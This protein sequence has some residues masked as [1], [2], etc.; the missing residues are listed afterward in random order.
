MKK[1][2]TLRMEQEAIERAKAYAEAR[3]TS[4]SKLVEHFFGALSADGGKRE[5]H[6]PLVEAL[7]GV[8]EDAEVSEADY[9]GHL[10]EKHG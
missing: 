9:Y 10:D 8:A 3:G 4:V 7:S 5:T 1:K 6:S 2:L